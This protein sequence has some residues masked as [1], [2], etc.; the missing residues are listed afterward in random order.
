MKLIKPPIGSVLRNDN[1]QSYGGS[2]IGQLNENFGLIGCWILNEGVGNRVY[3]L[4]RSEF[5]GDLLNNPS[6]TNGPDGP[7]LD[8]NRSN[9]IKVPFAGR[10][11][12]VDFSVSF[13]AKSDITNY[14]SNNGY[15]F[16]RY[17]YASGNR[18]WAIRINQSTDKWSL[19]TST[20]G[21]SNSAVDSALDVDTNWHH[22]VF[23]ASLGSWDMYVDG[24]LYEVLAPGNH[25]SNT[26]A[27]LTIGGLDDT[28]N[29]FDGKISHAMYWE[30]WLTADEVWRM[31]N[32]PYAL[33][34]KPSNDYYYYLDEVESSSNAPLFMNSY[35][36]MRA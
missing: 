8:F 1:F 4:S 32:D 27:F 16:A 18:V 36:R 34:K 20:N 17:D 11:G 5:H 14:T 12:Q 6:W 15:V 3:D 33:I 19:I 21:T 26:T 10:M 28:S 23:V 22:Y 30:Y 29:G 2:Y 9:R 13:Y 24:V 35:R 25:H 31:Y 7:A